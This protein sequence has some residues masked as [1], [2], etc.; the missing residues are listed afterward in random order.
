[1]SLSLFDTQFNNAVCCAWAATDFRILDRYYRRSYDDSLTEQEAKATAGIPTRTPAGVTRRLLQTCAELP[2]VPGCIDY[3]TCSLLQ[4]PQCLCKSSCDVVPPAELDFDGHS[5]VQG[6]TPMQSDHVRHDRY[7]L[8]TNCGLTNA[9]WQGLAT[10]RASAAGLC[11]EDTLGRISFHILTLFAA[12]CASLR[13][14][15]AIGTFGL[16]S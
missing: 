10:T 8:S 14:C 7:N 9:G 4:T 13:S 1:M 5:G 11:A 12:D 2:D 16:E 6:N 15:L 3:A